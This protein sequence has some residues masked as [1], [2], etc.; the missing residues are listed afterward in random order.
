MTWKPPVL[1]VAPT[2]SIA[3]IVFA[4]LTDAGC[5]PVV[6]SS[7]SEGKHQLDERPSLLISEVRLGE[8]NGLHLALRARAHGVPAVL[9]GQPD[10]VLQ[11]EAAQLGALYL[12]PPFDAQELLSA[13]QPLTS[14]GPIAP[15]VRYSETANVS[16]VSLRDRTRSSRHVHPFRS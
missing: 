15:R 14:T 10:L 6:V 16:F 1:V 5:G 8:Y 4:W 3:S 11:R 7:F 2:A 13:I 9:I 12:T